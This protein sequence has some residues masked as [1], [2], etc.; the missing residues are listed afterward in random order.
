MK[1]NRLDENCHC[2]VNPE[3]N[4]ETELLFNPT[5][6]S[7]NFV[8]GAGVSSLE[9]SFTAKRRG[10]HVTVYE[11]DNCPGGTWNIAA[12]PPYKGELVTFIKWQVDEYQRLGIRIKYNTHFLKM[13]RIIMMK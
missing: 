10:H 8:V 1:E 4:R 12:L 7:K 3:L 5:N 2:L 13:M 6:E 11:K 9:A